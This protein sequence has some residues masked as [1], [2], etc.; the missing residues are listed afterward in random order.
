VKEIGVKIRER[1]RI[2][3]LKEELEKRQEEKEGIKEEKY[4]I[5]R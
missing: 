4:K 2:I 3:L 5:S 1:L